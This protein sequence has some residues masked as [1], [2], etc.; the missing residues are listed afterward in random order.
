MAIIETINM[1]IDV[2][3]ITEILNIKRWNYLLSSWGLGIDPFSS[4]DNGGVIVVEPVISISPSLLST[5]ANTVNNSITKIKINDNIDITSINKS[6]DDNVV[7][8]QNQVTSDQTTTITKLDLLDSSDNILISATV[9]V[10]V[11][12][13]VD[14]TS[15]IWIN[16]N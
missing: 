13:S 4:N 9:Y 6:I 3:N 12:D 2:K 5:I 11:E 10:P 16:E 15:K 8:I 7:T 14:L 1:H